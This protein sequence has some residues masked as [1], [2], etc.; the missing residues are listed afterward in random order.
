MKQNS[1]FKGML[2]LLAIMLL[3]PLGA[4]AQWSPDSSLNLGIAVL[5][6]E[7]ATAKMVETSDGGC[8]ISWF[9]N[10]NGNYCMYLQLVDSEGH[11]RFAE[12]GLLISSH[13]QMTWLVDYDLTVDQDDNAVIVFSDIR[14][15]GTNDLD[16][17]AYKI[18]PDGSFL[19]GPDGVGLSPTVNTDFEPAP[20]V[21]ATSEGNFVVGWNKTADSDIICFQKI[22]SDGQKMWGEDG[23]DISDSL[24]ESLS[25]P[26]LVA[27]DNDSVIA[28]WKVSSGPPW[29][30]TTLLYTQKFDPDGGF[31]WGAS[32]VLIYDLGAISAWTYPLISS[33]GNGGAFYTWYDSPT[34]A[35]TVRVQH[36]DAGG[37]L[38]FPLNGIEASTN[39]SNRLHMN[40]SLSYM[41][42][43]NELYV[44]WV[45][46]NWNQSQWGLYGQK[47]S[48]LG[49]RLWT[50]NGME[51]LGLGSSQ[52]SFVRSGVTDSSV[53]VGYFESPTVITTAVKAFRV[54]RDGMTLWAPRLLSIAELGSKDDLLMVV[55]TENRAFLSWT[56]DRNGDFDIY[57]QNVNLDGT[58]GNPVS[59]VD[60]SDWQLPASYKLDPA[61][62]NPFNPTTMLS[63]SLPVT[64]NVHFDV[65]DVTG[66]HVA[67]LING[68]LSSGSHKIA[69]DG[70]R[71]ASGIY[72]YRLQAGTFASTR[73]MVLIK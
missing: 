47:F 52:I 68:S 4:N 60:D 31:A 56:D 13:T 32:G 45:E 10:R 61:Y 25:S 6:G 2:S 23:I 71:L 28:I 70:S 12:N 17:F 50:D 57:A 5:A 36:V 39:F 14:N 54:D 34:N 9:D 30:P 49:N 44:F 41:T 27:A 43:T 1:L 73:K 72:F 42:S 19:W 58:L 62:P 20:K 29:A 40:P 65:F 11:F 15:G 38:V 63:F 8:Y 18:A 59:G 33:D 22:S 24:G 7:Q 51:Y 69:F 55:N 48:P 35:F 3:I 37:N 64:S 67:T 26:D 66:R 16:V 53:Y 46:T 21:T